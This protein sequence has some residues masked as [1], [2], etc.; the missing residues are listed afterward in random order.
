MTTRNTNASTGK[1][2]LDVD[3]EKAVRVTRSMLLK[4]A[5]YRVLS[6][7]DGNEALRLFGSHRPDL[8]LLDY[9]MPG[10]DGGTT[11][12]QM[13]LLRADVP[14]ILISAYVHDCDALLESV[15]EILEKGSGPQIM[16]TKIAELLDQGHS[17][18]HSV[19]AQMSSTQLDTL[20]VQR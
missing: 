11:A 16:L 8:V 3:D 9:R 5:G 19:P 20:G 14:I 2:I 13:K 18:P 4:L 17:A 12:K 10:M 6:A 15:D 1:L 7:A